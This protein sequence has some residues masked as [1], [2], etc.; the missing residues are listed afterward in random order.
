M[1][2]YI[3]RGG[4]PLIG[5]VEV[6]GMKNAALP[7]LYATILVGGK[8]TLE[9]IP[10]ISDVLVTLEILKGMGAEIRMINR[11]T[12]EIDTTNVRGGSSNYQLVRTIRGSYY[13]LGCEMGRFGRAHVGFPGGCD[14][15]SR[16]IDFHIKGFEALGGKVR[17][18]GG[19]ISIT[20]PNGIHGAS[21]YFDGSSVGA[22]INV[23]MA[24]VLAK[25][26]T[27]ID[28]AAKE[29]HVVDVA[30][31]LNTCGAKITGAGTDVIKIRGVE[32]LHGRSY[33]II[34]D[35]IEAGTYMIAAAATHGKVRINNVIPKHLESVAA[36]LEEVGAKVEMLDDSVIVTGARKIRKTTVKT[37]PYPGFPTD[38]HP[39]F[40]AL[41]SVAPGVSYITETIWPK[42]FRYI[43]EL[44]CMGA[45]IK[46]DGNTAIIEGVPELSSAC[47]K[48]VDLR[49]GCSVLIAGLMAKGKT[50][51]Y[52]IKY[53]ER[54]YDDIVTK[55]SGLGANIMKVDVPEGISAQRAN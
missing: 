32:R 26:T 14:F 35:M 22:T 48:A 31:F 28:N 5:D 46:V 8:C 36:K 34:P 15:G 38:L 27:T 13:L 21:I 52:D 33:A 11:T 10:N 54:G 40:A 20:T 39:Q 47:V 9:H 44:N 51:I 3:L 7:I 29:P 49:A 23:M 12:Y 55:L 45:S 4:V 2:K 37:L 41:L 42:R 17:T 43:N 1:E 18:E 24:A 53:I 19:Y 50:E 6:S 30:N 25:G 16:P